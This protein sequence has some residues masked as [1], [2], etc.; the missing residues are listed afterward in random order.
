[1]LRIAAALL[2]VLFPAASAQV[3]VRLGPDPAV[4]RPVQ[5]DA[6]A[7]Q[8]VRLPVTVVNATT[9]PLTVGNVLPDGSVPCPAFKVFDKAGGAP[10]MVNPAVMDCV[11][12]KAVTLK[13]GQRRVFQV[14]VPFRLRPGEYTAILTV[15]TLPKP[16]PARATLRIGPGPF[17]AGL[18]FPAV[19]QANR[20]IA[21]DVVFT[22]VWRSPARDAI[23]LCHTTGLMVRRA[24]GVVVYNDKARGCADVLDE[25]TLAPGGQ[26]VRRRPL[27][28]LP[29]GEYTAILWGKWNT[30]AA[31]VVN[32]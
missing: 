32:P 25:P 27:P 29:A 12:G 19:M 22:N 28:P 21:M 31:F 15:P 20:G 26:S 8:P 7:E 30:S 10:M 3:K 18:R 11:V 6:L 14:V 23:D 17:V 24:D 13:P 2:L 16:T 1:M 5:N 4:S 9:R